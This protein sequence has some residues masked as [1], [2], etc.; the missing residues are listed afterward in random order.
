MSDCNDK[1]NDE[2][3]ASRP[4][5][6]QFGQLTGLSIGRL[7]GLKGEIL[8]TINEWGVEEKIKPRN[9]DA[10]FRRSRKKERER[11]RRGARANRD[12]S[13]INGAAAGV[14]TRCTIPQGR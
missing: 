11:E 1:K 10:H 6:R 13:Y 2:K 14:Q 5:G 8:I 7:A 12:W 3:L 9:P 4:T